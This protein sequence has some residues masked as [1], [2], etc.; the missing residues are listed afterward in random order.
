MPARTGFG[1]LCDSHH[2]GRTDSDR[3]SGCIPDN[4]AFQAQD[5]LLPNIKFPNQA[6][7]TKSNQRKKQV[8]RKPT[9]RQESKG[10]L[11]ASAYTQLS[12]VPLVRSAL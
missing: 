4:L 3:S 5:D 7:K 11:D 10:W 12:A 6:G 1:Q 2:R 9:P 8:Q